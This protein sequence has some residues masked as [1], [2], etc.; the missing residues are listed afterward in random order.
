MADVKEVEV[1]EGATGHHVDAGAGHGFGEPGLGAIVP[2]L[3]RDQSLKCSFGLGFFVVTP[4]EAKDGRVVILNEHCRD[5]HFE[6]GGA[7][8]F[9]YRSSALSYLPPSMHLPARRQGS[10]HSAA[11]T[12]PLGT[13]GHSSPARSPAV[14]V[15]GQG[16]VVR[17]PE[18]DNSQR[19]CI[20]VVAV[21]DA[22]LPWPT[23]QVTPV[24]ACCEEGRRRGCGLLVAMFRVGVTK[25]APKCGGGV[26][27]I[28]ALVETVR[29]NASHMIPCSV[30]VLLAAH[31]LC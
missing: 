10:L 25:G 23:K 7:M 11:A 3:L 19:V 2:P 26:T 22:L 30:A 4:D 5:R 24:T 16:P 18:H 12:S 27:L 15:H 8:A 21:C 9:I 29:E 31:A 20:G 13:L 6:V 14:D 28:P 17:V 1:L